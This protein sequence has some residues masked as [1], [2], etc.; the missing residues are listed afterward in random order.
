MGSIRNC[1]TVGKNHT[2]RQL[3]T[4]KKST[5]TKNCAKPSKLIDW[6]NCKP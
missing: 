5:K 6:N 3:K 4:A 2:K 1:K